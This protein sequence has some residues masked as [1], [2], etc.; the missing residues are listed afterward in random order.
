MDN[1][2]QKLRKNKKILIYRPGVGINRFTFN[3]LGKL[4]EPVKRNSKLVKL[5][6]T[7]Y[8]QIRINL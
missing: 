8:F 5:R 6:L 3:R 4:R 7:G 2:F 1:V